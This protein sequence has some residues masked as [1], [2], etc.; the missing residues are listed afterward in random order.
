VLASVSRPLLQEVV[1]GISANSES[2]RKIKSGRF[3]S[4]LAPIASIRWFQSGRL[5]ICLKLKASLDS[6]E[7][8]LDT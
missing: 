4:L 8:I 7:K 5:S 6:L 2:F 3:G 1:P